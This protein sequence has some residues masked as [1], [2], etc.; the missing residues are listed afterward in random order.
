MRFLMILVIGFAIGCGLG[1]WVFNGLWMLVAA[2][3]C[4]VC[5]SLLRFIHTNRVR[6]II[7]LLCIGMAIG[8]CWMFGYDAFYL[9]AA[10][11]LDGS[12]KH[13][14]I[15]L[16]DYSVESY[17]G[18]AGEGKIKING[19]SYKVYFYLSEDLDLYPGTVVRGDFYFRFTGFGGQD[20]AT[21]HQGDGIFLV[22]YANDSVTYE[23]PEKIP[24]R[25][26]PA[27][28]RAQIVQKLGKIF[29][30]MYLVFQKHC[31]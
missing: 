26:F 18:S 25:Y 12:T 1:I 28:F 23:N 10:R 5:W 2:G 27:Y 6:T 16:T 4:I 31:Y 24:V 30:R 29:P 7:S 22:A 14:T 20:E 15:E 21:Y 13:S 3:A 8:L 11:K 9:D 17:R 19:T